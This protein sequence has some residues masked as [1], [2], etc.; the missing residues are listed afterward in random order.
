MTLGKTMTQYFFF[1]RH[2]TALSHLILSY[3]TQ[4]LEEGVIIIPVFQMRK[5]MLSRV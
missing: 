1:A 2:F 4:P 5:T 3:P